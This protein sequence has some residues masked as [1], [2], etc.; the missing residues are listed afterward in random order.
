MIAGRG[1]ATRQ[2]LLGIQRRLERVAKGAALLRRKREALVTELFRLARPA[3]RARVSI[4]ERAMTAYPLLLDALGDEGYAGLRVI[5]WPDRE[6]TVQLQP[7]QV[8]GIPISEIVRRPPLQRSLSGR[9]A[10]PA[11]TAPSAQVTATAFETLTELL[12]DAA[13]REALLRRLGDAL[14][15]TSRQVNTLERRLDPA[16]RGQLTAVRRTLDEREREEHLRLGHLLRRSQQN[17]GPPP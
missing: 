11:W 1:P 15:R 17:G 9:G 5:G 2:N 12:L 14:A 8:W 6:L 16:L 10:S 3:A 4:A 13:G 7:G